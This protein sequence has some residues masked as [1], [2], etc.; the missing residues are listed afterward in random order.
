MKKWSTVSVFIT[1][2]WLAIF[3]L[4]GALLSGCVN[5]IKPDGT[6]KTDKIASD[7]VVA[8]K[9]SDLVHKEGNIAK[10]ADKVV[11]LVLASLQTIFDDDVELAE[12]F[13]ITKVANPDI[14]TSEL[15]LVEGA[16]SLIVG[17][18]E[19]PEHESTKI[20]LEIVSLVDDKLN[21]TLTIY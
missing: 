2:L 15:S 14:D 7:I 21:P 4:I 3:T 1:L 18:V 11:K 12:V 19:I 8:I 16:F 9:V 6:I 10:E 5:Y 13:E 17:R 20:L